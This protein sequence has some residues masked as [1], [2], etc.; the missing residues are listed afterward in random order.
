VPKVVVCES[1]LKP[2]MI[3]VESSQ[4]DGTYY[5]VIASTLFN[6]PVCECRGFEFR[7][8]CKHVTLVEE[9]RCDYHRLPDDWETEKT[10]GFCPHCRNPLVLFELEPEFD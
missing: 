2:Q 3:P 1:L 4:G 9:T 10:S 8:T 7:G 6:D 5:T